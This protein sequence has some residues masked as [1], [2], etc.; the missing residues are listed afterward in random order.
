MCVLI[1]MF[2]EIITKETTIIASTNE[3]LKKKIEI[4]LI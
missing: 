3:L 1:I 4:E 2:I